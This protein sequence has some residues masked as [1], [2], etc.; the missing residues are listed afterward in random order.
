MTRTCENLLL[1]LLSVTPTL[2]FQIYRLT[3]AKKGFKRI[4]LYTSAWYIIQ[5]NPTVKYWFLIGNQLYLIVYTFF[6]TFPK[7]VPADFFYKTKHLVL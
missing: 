5:E 1:S 7:K 3:K 2:P 6:K 4:Y